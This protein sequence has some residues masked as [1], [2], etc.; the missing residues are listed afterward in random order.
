MY[1]N[2]RID[3]GYR[4]D[5]L[6]EDIVIVEIQSIERFDRI[7]AAQLLSYLRLSGREVGLLINFN[8]EFLKDGIRRL[9]QNRALKTSIYSQ[10]SR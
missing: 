8:V 9:T 2:V 10:S 6:V 1:N 7:H 5:F 4:L 3:C